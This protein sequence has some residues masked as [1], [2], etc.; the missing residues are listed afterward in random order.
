MSTEQPLERALAMSAIALAD[1]E[2]SEHERRCQLAA[3]AKD[4]TQEARIREWLPEAFGWV[5]LRA[6]EG[7]R[8]PGTFHV[9]DRDGVWHELDMAAEPMFDD[10]VL[11][12]TNMLN[13]EMRGVFETLALRSSMVRA[14]NV[15]LNSGANV[16][17]VTISG[18]AF[19]GLRTEYYE[20]KNAGKI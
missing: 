19:I 16:R 18:P 5:L 11:L 3:Y 7:L 10:M 2:L 20:G 4:R 12:A 6:V 15:A 9:R 17:T 1:T 13:S 14:L 8:L